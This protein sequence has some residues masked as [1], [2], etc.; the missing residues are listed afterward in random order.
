MEGTPTGL[1][2]RFRANIIRVK[3]LW[4]IGL[5]LVSDPT[6]TYGG[7]RDM[8]ITMGSGTC[9]GFHPRLR[10]STVPSSWLTGVAKRDVDMAF[11]NLS[12]C[13]TQAYKGR[14]LFTQPLGAGRPSGWEASGFSMTLHYAG[15]GRWHR[16]RMAPGTQSWNLAGRGPA[17]T[18]PGG[19]LCCIRSILRRAQDGVHSTGSDEE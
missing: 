11:V 19:R 10:M 9:E 4:E 18:L 15:E 2:S 12:A 7:N 14:G 8:T 5:H 1:G 13:L 3:T 6:I 16:G 17:P